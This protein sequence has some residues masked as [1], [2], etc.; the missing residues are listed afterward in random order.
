MSELHSMELSKCVI[1]I[2]QIYFTTV[3]RF[4]EGEVQLAFFPP[5]F[6]LFCLWFSS[7]RLNP[8]YVEA[9]QEYQSSVSVGKRTLNQK[10]FTNVQIAGITGREAVNGIYVLHLLSLNFGL[11][12]AFVCPFSFQC[13]DVTGTSPYWLS[14]NLNTAPGRI[15]TGKQGDKSRLQML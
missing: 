9:N 15:F 12:M 8:N 13:N 11:I 5:F 10:V 3:L 14:S 4:W 2:Q 1:F 7:V 6:L